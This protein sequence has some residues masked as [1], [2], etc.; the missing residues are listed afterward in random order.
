MITYIVT[1]NGCLSGVYS[2]VEK[3]IAFLDD[4]I[5]FYRYR[6]YRVIMDE[7]LST[8]I[9]ENKNCFDVRYFSYDSSFENKVKQI[10]DFFSK[11]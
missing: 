7:V 5:R 4:D 6:I 3:A 11:D 10:N 8:K 2:S 9:E 1:S